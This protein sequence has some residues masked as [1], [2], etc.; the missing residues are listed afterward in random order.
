V[1]PVKLCWPSGWNPPQVGYYHLAPNIDA[2]DDMGADIWSPQC[3]EKILKADIARSTYGY[4]G[5]GI[6]VAVVDTGFSRWPTYY[7]T[8]NGYHPFYEEYYSD[9]LQN[10]YTPYETANH[11]PDDDDNGHGT[12]IVPNLLAIAPGINLHFISWDSTI[13]AFDII[14]QTIQPDVVSCSWLVGV[15]PPT[16][17]NELQN[18][19]RQCSENGMILVFAAG[20]E[21]YEIGWPASE[22]CVVAA[23]GVYVDGNGNLEASSYA[24]SGSEETFG[25]RLVPDFCGIVGQ[26][27]GGIPKEHGILIELPTEVASLLDYDVSYY[28][29]ETA[30]YDGWA[31]FS[32]TSSATP[33]I[34][35]LA[36]IVKQIDSEIDDGRFKH[37]VMSTCTD[38]YEGESYSSDAAQDGFD[39]ATGAGLINVYR[40]IKTLVEH[41]SL[42]SW[43]AESL[44]AGYTINSYPVGSTGFHVDTSGTSQRGFYVIGY[45]AARSQP[46]MINHEYLSIHGQFRQ[47]DTLP[48]HLWEGRRYL[49]LYIL[50]TD[51]QRILQTIQI[52]NHNDGTSW[53]TV[54]KEITFP[55]D[56]WGMVRIAFGRVDSWTT[57]WQITAEWRCIHISDDNDW[58]GDTKPDGMH[59]NEF[60]LEPFELTYHTGYHVD[61]IGSSQRGYYFWIQTLDAFWY[62][63]WWTDVEI[64]ISGW[65]RQ[66]DTLYSYLW[67]GRRYVNAYVIN[68]Q[69]EIVKTHRIL[70]WYDG[71]DWEYRHVHF[72]VPWQSL[73]IDPY[74]YYYVVFGRVDSWSSDWKLT[75]ELCCAQITIGIPY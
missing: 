45:L 34:A 26:G 5:T 9:L 28:G 51:G 11:H 55:S 2:V 66:Y 56:I 53:K 50:S 41:D 22:P 44:P 75:V 3:V 24:C 64:S 73:C 40:A 48:P 58:I 32:G 70:E 23:G 37:L 10:R 30:P 12:G 59:Y 13:E 52:L 39:R 17:Q 46:I 31:V 60:C 68:C 4:D 36:A 54:D 18:K 42:F 62:T 14:L 57:D 65:F 15:G 74:P 49:N 29:D 63:L 33:Q 8:P 6:D 61:T 20:N 16:G 35:G 27:T 69:G 47:Y 19:I 25:G 67:E 72:T 7:P 43:S 38:V 21:P 1:N 71:T